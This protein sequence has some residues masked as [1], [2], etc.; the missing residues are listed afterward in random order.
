[1]FNPIYKTDQ[2]EVQLITI[3]Q[4]KIVLD[5]NLISDEQKKAYPNQS[6]IDFLIA[7]SKNKALKEHIWILIIVHENGIELIERSTPE[8]IQQ[9][10]DSYH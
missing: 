4:N 10:I 2:Q 9:V 7:S 6:K 1:M 3:F 8:A 5:L